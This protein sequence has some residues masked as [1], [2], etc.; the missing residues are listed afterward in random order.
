MFYG[1]LAVSP[2]MPT[3]AM[4]MFDE[5]ITAEGT[6]TLILPEGIVGDDEWYQSYG[7]TGKMNVL[8][9]LYFTIGGSTPG[10]DNAWT[11]DPADGSTVSSLHVIHVWNNTVSEMGCGGG[12]IVVKKDVGVWNGYGSFTWT[13]DATNATVTATPALTQAGTATQQA[14]ITY[15]VEITGFT[16]SGNVTLNAK[17]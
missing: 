6:Y 4:V 5:P 14:T 17:A 2:K 3:R 16:C 9:N 10:G 11:T 15:Q 7:E 8:T 12:K 1:E 13:I